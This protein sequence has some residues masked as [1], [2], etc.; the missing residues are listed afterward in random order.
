P[1]IENAMIVSFRAD[2]PSICSDQMLRDGMQVDLMHSNALLAGI[3]KHVR[4]WMEVMPVAAI[5]FE[6][7]EDPTQ[8]PTSLR[9]LGLS[10]LLNLVEEGLLTKDGS[11][12]K[13]QPS[14]EV[15]LEWFRL[16]T[17]IMHALFAVSY[18][19][20]HVVYYPEIVDRFVQSNFVSLQIYMHF[21]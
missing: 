3:E 12:F 21:Y 2:S 9:Q 8:I 13:Y 15:M 18:K 17:D 16:A 1:K 11:H 10:S 7:A 14:E 4:R 20:G 6:Y 5:H 19:D